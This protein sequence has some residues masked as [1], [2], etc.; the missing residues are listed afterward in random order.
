MATLLINTAIGSA[1]GPMGGLISQ[2]ATSL[3]TQAFNGTLFGER[4]VVEGPRLDNLNMLASTEGAP[5]PRVYGRARIGGQMIWAT[6]FIETASTTRSGSSGGKSVSSLTRSLGGGSSTDTISYSYAANFAVGLCEGEIAFV[7]RIWADGKEIDRTTFNHRVHRGGADQQADPLIVAKEGAENA[8]AYRGLAYVV[9]EAFPLAAYGNRIPQLTF[10]VVK[11][12]HGLCEMVR[13]VDLIPG[14]SEYAYSVPSL[15]QSSGGVSV[16][17]NRHQ[18]SGASDWT[19]SLDALQAL[20]PN[21]KRVALVVSWFG[22]DMRAGSCRIAPRV[23]TRMKPIA[24]SPWSCAGLT[25]DNAQLVSQIDGKPALGGTPSDESLRSALADLRARGLAVLFYPFVM[26]DVPFGNALPDPRTGAPGQTAFGWRGDIAPASPDGGAAATNEIATFFANDRYRRFIL[27][28]AQLCASAGGV[29]SFLVGSELR[30]VT[31]ARGAD[32]GYPAAA[33][34]ARLAA[35]VKA[36]LGA[37]TKVSYGADWSEFGALSR[38]DGRELRFPLDAL[39]ASPSIDFVGLD[40]YFPLSD[41]RAGGDHLDAQVARSVHDRDYLRARVASGEN[42][43]WYYASDADRAAQL[44]TPISDGALGKPWVFRAKD[45]VNWWSQP[46]VERVNGAETNATAWVPRSK[47]IWFVEFGCPAID[48]GAN[49]PNVFP[50]A[51]QMTQTLPPFSSGARDDLIQIRAIE[52]FISRFDPACDGFSDAFNPVAPG[53]WRMVDPER[54]YLWA[55][56]ARPFPAFPMTGDSWSDAACWDTGHW[57]NGRL[58][59]APLDRLVRDIVSDMADVAIHDPPLD[60]IVDGY[61]IDRPLS[62]RGVLEPLCA[63][64]SFDAIASSGALRFRQRRDGKPMRLTADDLAPM[65]DGALVQVSRTDDS[66]LP[67]EISLG[68]TNSEWDYRSISALSRRVQGASKRHSEAEI[69][70]VARLGMV[71]R[72]ANVW[73]QDLWIAREGAEAALRP[74]LVALEPGDLVTLPVGAGER[75]F[76]IERASGLF[77]RKITCR[78]VDMSVHDAPA[79]TASRASVAAPA[80]AGAPRVELLDLAIARSDPPTLQYLAA[81]AD[82]WPGP[83]ALWTS[84]GASF[85]FAGMIQRSA[86]M[87][88]TLDVLKA[89]PVGRFD[90]ANAVRVK[91]RGGALSSAADAHVLAGRNRM[92]VRGADGAF[93]ILAFANAELVGE[94]TW[95]LSRLLR[96]MGGEEYLAARDAPA[97]ALA[98]V[99]DEALVGLGEGQSALGLSRTYA[100][101]PAALDYADKSYVRVSGVA[102]SLALRPYAPVRAQARRS[103]SGVEI[104]FIRRTRLDGDAWEGLD[105]PL[106]EASESYAID[107]L[108]GDVVKRTLRSPTQALV[109]AAAD[110]LA[111]FGARQAQLRLRI[112]Q[113]STIAGGG[114]ELLADV[115]IL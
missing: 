62:A 108:A 87:G 101:G 13:A 49:A 29:E 60:S 57:L 65:Q 6:R 89:G 66:R 15:M 48:A 92:A 24:G 18:L 14:S 114:F 30:G 35:D 67:H 43:D 110:E 103:A 111:D 3:A 16:S 26:M 86:I 93:E 112:A 20:C 113:S 32:G 105:A 90:R 36:V 64:F 88:E 52:A 95:R 9:F 1:S 38:D 22:D 33:E 109:Y 2:A 8:P 83:L 34:L 84:S 41:W 21:L 23:E 76:R 85:E 31:R 10:E 56:D 106:G 37:Q 42:F 50:D 4:R 96:G 91:M 55:Y 27:Y 99:L 71:Q 78:A 47:P 59:A 104:S 69:A 80:M 73:L 100:V 11:P 74:G 44:R 12:V 115:P 63:L 58:E 94:N 45:L 97:G 68:F 40:A 77:E 17:E 79:P 102:G 28:Y 98:V 7:R 51:K 61:V 53:G 75:L 19:M 82:P 5:I 25:R 81:F 54:I 72:A 107:I 70:L 46:H 39:W